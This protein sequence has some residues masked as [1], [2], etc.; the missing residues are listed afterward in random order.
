MIVSLATIERRSLIVA[1]CSPKDRDIIERALKSSFF[2]EVSL[3]SLT[4]GSVDE[5]VSNLEVE[6]RELD[7][8]KAELSKELRET[9]QEVVKE[10]QTLREKVSLA[11][12]ILRAQLLYA[13][14]SRSYLIQGWVPKDRIEALQKEVLRVT[15]GRARFDISEPEMIEDVRQGKLKIPILFNN[16]YL[17]RPFETIVFNYGTHWR[18]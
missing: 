10:L 3:P 17:I 9:Q 8:R 4:Q 12:V 7:A 2:E 14:G 11:L 15:E 5:T 1:F 16:P 6:A 13:R 18:H